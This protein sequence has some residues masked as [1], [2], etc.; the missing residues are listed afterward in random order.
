MVTFAEPEAGVGFGT[1]S[2]NL[3]SGEG[4]HDGKRRSEISGLAHQDLM[5]ETRV[6]GCPILEEG[7]PNLLFGTSWTKRAP[8]N[9][10]PSS[11]ICRTGFLHD[12]HENS[13]VEPGVFGSEQYS[14]PGR[15][16][17]NA[18]VGVAALG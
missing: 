2:L 17:L 6:E 3:D 5:R 1:G 14:K 9:R 15:S 11:T 8:M 12:I 10:V 16:T 13:F 7:S 4:T 18:L